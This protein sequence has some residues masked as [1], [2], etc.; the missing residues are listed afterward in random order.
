MNRVVCVGLFLFFVGVFFVVG[1]CSVEASSSSSLVENSWSSK[2]SMQQARYG[3][4]VVAVEGK[5]YAIGGTTTGRSGDKLVGT[6]EMY[7]PVTNT[8]TP[9]APMPT[10]RENFAIA[11]YQNKIYCISGRVGESR[12]V[13]VLYSGVVSDVVEVYDTTTNIWSKMAPLPHS[14]EY[15]QAS[16][17]NGQLFVLAGVHLVMYDLLAGGGWTEK[18]RIPVSFPVINLWHGPLQVMFV[19]DNKLIVTG[20]FASGPKV[21]VY[22]PVFDVWSEEGGGPMIVCD[23]VGLV[24]SGV[25]AS[26]RVYFLGS[27]PGSTFGEVLTNQAY[28]F[29]D[30][31]WLLG[32]DIP[33]LRFNFGAAI[34]DD[35][36]YVIGGYG[37]SEM[38]GRISR[39]PIA[40]NE[41][42]VPF[43]YRTIPVVEVVS[44]LSEAVYN[45][46]SVDLV[47]VVDRPVSQL[48]FCVNG[49]AN[50]T[51][52]DYNVSLSGLSGGVYSVTVFAE[53]KYGNVGVS[54]TV[55]FTVVSEPDPILTTPVVVV[56]CVVPVLVV[57]VV[58][59]LF[60]RK[61]R[62]SKSLPMG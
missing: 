38:A 6:N 3:L 26:Q 12:F 41:A 57:T 22:D 19:M 24:T 37:Y 29:S 16:V 44:P 31:S 20:E 53:D 48:Y 49:G 14:T 46:S 10:P 33:N 42:Y 56:L 17:V 34:V 59:F 54:E 25:F 36:L 5:I 50:V 43:G 23:G 30:N 1:V 45:V 39:V 47:F 32:A 18:A 9:L 60:L 11:T 58:L 62:C 52:A 55:V 40:L 4:G 21:L 27:A 51:V 8:W 35:V 2:T 61:C 7:D 28:D 15:L 13:P